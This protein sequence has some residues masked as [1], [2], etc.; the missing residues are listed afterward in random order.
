MKLHYNKYGKRGMKFDI[1][2]TKSLIKGDGIF[3]YNNI[4]N[5]KSDLNDL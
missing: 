3:S 1:T 4:K 5:F 2:D